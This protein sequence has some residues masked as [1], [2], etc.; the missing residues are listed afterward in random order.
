MIFKKEH[1]P[2][3]EQLSILRKGEEWNEEASKRLKEERERKA[4]EEKEYTN[5]RKQ[6]ENFVPNICDVICLGGFLHV[7]KLIEVPQIVSNLF[8]RNLKTSDVKKHSNEITITLALQHLLCK[9]NRNINALMTLTEIKH[10]YKEVKGKKFNTGKKSRNDL[11]TSARTWYYTITRSFCKMGQVHD[12]QD[13]RQK[14][15]EATKLFS[16]NSGKLGES[17]ILITLEKRIKLIH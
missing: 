11:D 9:L 16:L 7:A 4:K 5:S 17:L 2:S 6:K 13:K 12:E 15:A 3:D 8:V 1:A 14:E 10:D